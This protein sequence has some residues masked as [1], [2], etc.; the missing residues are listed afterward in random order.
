M[1]ETL[2]TMLAVV[3]T[4]N[5]ESIVRALYHTPAING[6]DSNIV[7][8]SQGK[9]GQIIESIPRS[10]VKYI[11]VLDADFNAKNSNISFSMDPREHKVKVWAQGIHSAI[12]NGYDVYL[13]N[14]DEGFETRDHL[15]VSDQECRLL[16]ADCTETEV[17]NGYC[18]GY[19]KGQQSYVIINLSNVKLAISQKV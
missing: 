11:L 2:T 6:D 18:V 9:E 15:E 13:K 1:S 17:Q 10:W 7:I 14:A 12:A 5:K 8:V 4:D 16:I 3:C 19:L